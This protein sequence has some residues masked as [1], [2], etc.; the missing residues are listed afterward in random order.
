MIPDG[1]ATGRAGVLVP[2]AGV[3]PLSPSDKCVT[4]R[5]DADLRGHYIYSI[6]E[7]I[8][9]KRSPGRFPGTSPQRTLSS[10]KYTDVHT[11]LPRTRSTQTGSDEFIYIYIYICRLEG[12]LYNIVYTSI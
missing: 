12:T 10:I 7:Y 11:S 2:S 4:A 5:R 1:R 6:Y 8:A 3:A 9:S